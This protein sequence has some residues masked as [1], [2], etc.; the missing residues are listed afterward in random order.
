M[1]P[2]K[3]AFLSR[4]EMDMSD[5]S[6]ISQMSILSCRMQT[7]VLAAGRNDSGRQ[8]LMPK[9]MSKLFSFMEL[10]NLLSLMY[11]SVMGV[12]PLGIDSV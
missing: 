1:R 7:F 4:M 3:N 10:E 2:G 5:V 6:V 12:L 9:V 8:N 11:D